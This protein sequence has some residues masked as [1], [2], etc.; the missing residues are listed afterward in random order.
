M[1]F[2]ALIGGLVGS[3][4]DYILQNWDK[5]SGDLL[6]NIFSGSGLV[7]FGGLVGGALGV[8]LWARWR[9]FLGWQL[10]DAAAVPLAVGYAIGRVGCQLSGDGDYGTHSDLPV[11]DVLPGRHGPDH[12]HRAPHARVRDARDGG[13]RRGAVAPARPLRAGRAVRA[14][15]DRSPGSS[16]SWSSSSG[17]TRRSWPASRSRSSSPWRC[18][19]SAWPS[20]SCAATCPSPPRPERGAHRGGGAERQR[21]RRA[22]CAVGVEGDLDAHDA[23]DHGDGRTRQ[24]RLTRRAGMGADRDR[25]RRSGPPGRA[26]RRGPEPPR[27]RRRR[28]GPAE[29]GASGRGGRRPRPRRPGR[30]PPRRAAGGARRARRRRA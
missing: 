7:W 12:G 23:R 3:R 26:A 10:F 5:V 21:H 4:I 25:R 29:R 6:G 27:R 28:G 24:H 8:I 20:W 16:A 11:G 22:G 13:R 15:P 17:A 2:A 1:V 30:T 9:G 18:W 19:R 14:L